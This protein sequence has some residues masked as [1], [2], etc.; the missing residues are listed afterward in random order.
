M[1][2]Q[3]ALAESAKHGLRDDVLERLMKINALLEG[4][5]AEARVVIES[6]NYVSL[7]D[8]ALADLQGKLRV[9]AK[10]FGRVASANA[11]RHD[12][13]LQQSQCSY[14]MISERKI[15]ERVIGRKASTPNSS[16]NTANELFTDVPAAS[17]P[18]PAAGGTLETAGLAIDT[19]PGTPLASTTD[20]GLGD[21]VELF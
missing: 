3:S 13:L 19:R 6:V 11:A 4:I 12:G 18:S 5:R 2:T 16:A 10:R 9:I 1:V 20:L 14:T 15:F 7:A 17:L 8:P 21:N